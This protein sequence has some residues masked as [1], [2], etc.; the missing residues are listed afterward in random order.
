MIFSA[1]PRNWSPEQRATR[2]QSHQTVC[3]LPS[4]GSR[5]P[6][7][8]A[9]VQ[10]LLLGAPQSPAALQGTAL[11][12][13]EEA[14]VFGRSGD[15]GQEPSPP[16]SRVQSVTSTFL[17]RGWAGQRESPGSWALGVTG[18][19]AQALSQ[20]TDPGKHPRLGERADLGGSTRVN[21]VLALTATC[22]LTSA[23]NCDSGQSCP[24]DATRACPYKGVNTE[25]GAW[26]PP[27]GGS[28]HTHTP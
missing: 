26:S 6:R 11:R 22:G 20:A 2:G 9:S 8:G 4:A 3:M 17:G 18:S 13:E 21:C 16:G 12:A 23:K 25:D 28:H 14:E 27:R 10:T 7:C 1:S 24:R 5:P 15:S 19:P